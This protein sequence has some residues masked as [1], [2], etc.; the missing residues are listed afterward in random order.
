MTKNPKNVHVTYDQD[1]KDWKVQSEGADRAAGRFDTKAEAEDAG[2]DIAQNKHGEL[3]I[4]NKDAK[5][6]ERNSYGHDPYPPKG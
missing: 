4:H 1:Q 6:S 5:I 2:K 3:F